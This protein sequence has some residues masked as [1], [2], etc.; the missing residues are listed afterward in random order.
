[1]P[2]KVEVRRFD[3]SFLPVIIEQGTAFSITDGNGNVAVSDDIASA[4]YAV[5]IDVKY[6]TA[7]V[8]GSVLNLVLYSVIVGVEL[9]SPAERALG[10][11]MKPLILTASAL[12][13]VYISAAGAV[14][15]EIVSRFIGFVTRILVAIGITAHGADRIHNNSALAGLLVKQ[16]EAVLVVMSFT[17]C[18]AGDSVDNRHAVNGVA[19][20]V[21]GRFITAIDNAVAV[22]SY[23]ESALLASLG[24][25]AVSVSV[26]VNVGARIVYEAAIARISVRP[27]VLSASAGIHTNAR[28]LAGTKLLEIVISDEACIVTEA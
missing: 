4:L 1:M 9:G 3:G 15:F 21:V 2:S 28:S 23:N 10:H 16:L 8:A 18:N 12:I 11:I 20:I 22:T 5:K 27:G 25:D 26:L 24:L 7:L 17:L 14:F 13:S 6:E 19:V